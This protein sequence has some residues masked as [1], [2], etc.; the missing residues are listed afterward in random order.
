MERSL[1]H[2]GEPLVLAELGAGEV[3]GEMGVLD[4]APRSATIVALE[5]THT[6]ELGATAL[7]VTMLDYPEVSTKLLHIFSQRLRSNDELI[8]QVLRA[9]PARVLP[10]H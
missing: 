6:V 5:P 2:L 3:F 4:Q 1:P 9:S 8:E 10:E 7:A